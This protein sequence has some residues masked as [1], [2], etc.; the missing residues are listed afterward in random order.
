MTSEI[1]V[2]KNSNFK[3][4]YIWINIILYKLDIIKIALKWREKRNYR[5]MSVFLVGTDFHGK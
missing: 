3:L 1:R 2:E 5:G 4:Y